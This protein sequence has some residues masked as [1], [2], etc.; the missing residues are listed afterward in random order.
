MTAQ[1]IGGLHSVRTA[2]KHGAESVQEIWVEERR[3]D[4]RVRELA[5]LAR[6][7]GIRVRVVGREE[8]DRLVSGANHQ[9]VVARTLMPVA[10]DEK[11]L[12]HLLDGLQAPVLLLILD[13][14]QD[15]HNL[16][17]C[18]RNADAAGVQAVIAPK[19]RSVGLTPTACKVAS[20]AAETVPFFQV[21]NLVR[22]LKRLQDRGIWLVGTTGDAEATLFDTRLDGHLGVL[23]GGEEKGMR[24]LTR[25][26]CDMLVKLPMA[27]QVESLNVSVAAGITLFEVIRQ[28]G[29]G[30]G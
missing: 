1:L 22:T 26:S 17:A 6:K 8:L 30:S 29:Q 2:L 19:D 21:T 24:R 7:Q 16:G 5:S 9:G 15:P 10:R 14:V 11:E 20:G 25:E 13:G 3:R 23:M 28:R 18:L 27:G 12:D 4:Q